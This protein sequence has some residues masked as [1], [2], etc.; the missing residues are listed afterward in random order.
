MI[1]Y[2]REKHSLCQEGSTA[3]CE[4]RSKFLPKR[5]VLDVD[6]GNSAPLKVT[7]VSASWQNVNGQDRQ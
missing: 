2:L 1:E 5:I 3:A 4:K 6:R 7:A